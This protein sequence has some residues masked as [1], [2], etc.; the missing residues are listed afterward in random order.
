MPLFHI[1]GLVAALLASLEAG[2][3]VACCPCFHQLRF[4]DWLADLKPTWYTAVPTMQAAV[5]AR[6]RDHQE[7][8]ANHRLR[9]IR[10]SS[11]VLPV[12]VLEGLEETFRVPVIE[13]YGMTE[14]AHQMASN[15]LP[16]GIRRPGTVGP[17]AGP[18]VAVLDESG[19]LLPSGELGEVAIR[20]RTSSSVMRRIQRR[21]RRRS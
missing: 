4:I 11:A 19:D 15:R 6:A 8:L 20:G 21:T 1:H 5:V 17:A 18:E 2:A 3:S 16:P 12:P 7:T 13:A 10:S 9:L 14:A